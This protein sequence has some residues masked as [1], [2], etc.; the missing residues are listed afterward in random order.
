MKSS[1]SRATTSPSTAP[2][3][4]IS[5]P[6][7]LPG[8]TGAVKLKKRAVVVDAGQRADVAAGQ[9]QR[10]AGDAVVG[11]ARG[12]HP[13]AEPAPAPGGERQPGRRRPG[14]ASAA[15][16]RSASEAT[17]RRARCRRRA[18]PGRSRATTCAA[19]TSVRGA[20]IEAGAGAAGAR[21][22]AARPPPAARR[23]RGR[24]AA[25]SASAR[26]AGGLGDEP[27]QPAVGSGRSQGSGG[28][29]RMLAATRFSVAASSGAAGEVD[30]CPAAVD[31]VR[32][33]VE[34]RGRRAARRR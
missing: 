24:V 9:V 25:R 11:E 1:E 28:P 19:V 12:V 33:G 3:A 17:Q 29:G 14:A 32:A 10:G 6:P 18:R 30:G 21:A 4:S 23:R 26:N 34:A 13:L 2:P 22:A 5:G 20:E 7:L 27:R 15:T 8:C 16:S 31:P